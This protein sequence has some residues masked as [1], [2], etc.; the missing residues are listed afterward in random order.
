MMSHPIT[1]MVDLIINVRG[2]STI[3]HVPGVSKNY[4]KQLWI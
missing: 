1:F 4:S 3:H 2:W